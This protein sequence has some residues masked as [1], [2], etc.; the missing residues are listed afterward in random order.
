MRK[1]VFAFITG[2]SLCTLRAMEE[3]REFLRNSKDQQSAVGFFVFDQ[4]RPQTPTIVTAPTGKGSNPKFPSMYFDTPCGCFSSN[5]SPVS[6][7]DR[8]DKNS[9]KPATSSDESRQGWFA[10]P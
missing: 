1:T 10:Y 6:G 2:I 5:V 3:K 4:P 9:I 8:Y 7:V